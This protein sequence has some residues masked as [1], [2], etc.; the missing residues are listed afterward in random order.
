M[1]NPSAVRDTDGEWF[2]VKNLSGRM[3]ALNGVELVSDD[4]DGH[5]ITA[6]APILLPVGAYAVFGRSVDESV[7]GSAD[8]WY[9]YQNIALE[10]ESDRLVLFADGVRLDEV[11]WDD[12]ETMPD[13]VGAAMSVD[14]FHAD[15]AG[16]DDPTVWCAASEAWGAGTDF[17]TPGDANGP[18]PQFDHDGDGWR[19]E[20]G[21]CDDEDAAVYPEAPE[22]TVGIDN[23]CDGEVGVMPV[24]RA[25]YNPVESSLEVSNPLYLDGSGSFDP[26][27][28][29]LYWAWALDE[30][31]ELSTATTD[32]ISSPSSESPV[33]TPD[34]VGVYR[35]SLIVN[36]GTYD[37]VPSRFSVTI[38]PGAAAG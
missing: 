2:E 26:D 31:P 21:D 29:G 30:V 3:L 17:G 9:A 4:D 23:D 20:D 15:A 35:F 25:D 36:D 28:G 32:W 13:P 8:V 6:D 34:V 1:I 14:P 12:G 11:I 7:N 10:N 22:I 16:N 19:G 5:I 27:G 33:F 37:S 18:C 24:A 38:G